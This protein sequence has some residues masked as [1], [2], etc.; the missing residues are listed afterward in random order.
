MQFLPDIGREPSYGLTTNVNFDPTVVQY[1]GGYTQI[2]E[3]DIGLDPRSWELS[4]DTIKPW[5]RDVLS[6]FFRAHKS[7]YRFLWKI[8]ASD[9]VVIVRCMSYSDTYTAFERF[10]VKVTVQE[11]RN[12][13]SS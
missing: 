10:N 4:W 8:P 7:V 13:T 3:K 5:Q 2:T 6:D 11:A 12:V 9:E 1:G